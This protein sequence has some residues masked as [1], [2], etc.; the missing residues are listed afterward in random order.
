MEKYKRTECLKKGMNYKVLLMFSLLMIFLIPNSAYALFG[1]FDTGIQ[2]SQFKFGQDDFETPVGAFDKQGA[3]NNEFLFVHVTDSPKENTT[4]RFYYTGDCPSVFGMSD[5]EGRVEF[6]LEN[7]VDFDLNTLCDT[8]STTDY[9]EITFP[10]EDYVLLGDEYVL[11][12]QVVM[13]VYSNDSASYN[14]STTYPMYMGFSN[15]Y[16]SVKEEYVF[17][18]LETMEDGIVD[19][20]VLMLSIGKFVLLLVEIVFVILVFL[21]IPFLI[22]TGLKIIMQKIRQLLEGI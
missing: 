7:P 10:E 21:S 6:D 20:V 22:I 2:Y 18:S 14:A 15:L 17:P 4:F 12:K 8:D 9:V 13:S 19:L 3:Y 5:A 1:G 11:S 16:V